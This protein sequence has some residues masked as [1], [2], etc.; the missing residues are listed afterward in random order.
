M[1]IRII[2]FLFHEH[3]F[4]PDVADV[5]S[6][7][8][9]RPALV[10]DFNFDVSYAY[11]SSRKQYNSTQILKG[12]LSLKKDDAEKYLGVTDVDL[13]I[14]ILTYVFG[15]AQLDGPAAVVS[16]FRLK[17]QFYGLP[18][19]DALLHDRIIKEAVH[20]LGHAFG[21]RHC[22]NYEC[23]MSSSTFADEIDLKGKTFCEECKV[24]LRL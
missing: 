1:G 19:N 11:D 2:P 8:F 13:F 21:L 15:E 9:Q 7:D 5:I 12:L 18:K 17:P 10:S 14:P 6:Q 20:E 16:T 23:V 22:D 3:Q 24:E 4:L